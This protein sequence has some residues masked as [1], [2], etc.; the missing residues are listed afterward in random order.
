MVADT[1]LI[2]RSLVGAMGFVAP[3]CGVALQEEG[4]CE[5]AGL[6]M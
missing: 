6:P 1:T 5:D 3:I 4:E 2:D